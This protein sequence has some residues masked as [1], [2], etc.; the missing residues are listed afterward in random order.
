MTPPTMDTDTTTTIAPKP[1]STPGKNLWI[2]A[3]IFL[4]TPAILTLAYFGFF[5]FVMH[6]TY[7]EYKYDGFSLYGKKEVGVIHFTPNA[8]PNN[9]DLIL[10]DGTTI[11]ADAISEDNL[12]VM[13]GQ[14]TVSAHNSDYF[15][16]ERLHVETLHGKIVEIRFY[17]PTIVN[18]ANGK[19]LKVE[20]TWSETRKVFG[21]PKAIKRHVRT[22]RWM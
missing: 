19:S 22:L 15:Q 8:L 5:Y 20:S 9:I 6:E 2:L 12:E 1:P 16:K 21:R 18:R 17:G 10:Y 4:G 13:F 11:R 7:W 14:A 3:A